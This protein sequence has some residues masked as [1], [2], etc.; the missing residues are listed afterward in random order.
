MEYR[1]SSSRSEWQSPC[2]IPE[3]AIRNGSILR[4]TGVGLIL[5]G[6]TLAFIV[7]IW[8]PEVDGPSRFSGAAPDWGTRLAIAGALLLSAIP[9]GALVNGLGAILQLLA[10]QQQLP[11]SPKDAD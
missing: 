1:S 9:L 7:I 6:I 2:I 4:Q 8:G 11:D 10:K 5:I 3:R